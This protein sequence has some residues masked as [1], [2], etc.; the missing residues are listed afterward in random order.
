MN[1]G[2]LKKILEAASATPNPISD[3]ARL[4]IRY[5]GG[6]AGST[7]N[8][9]AASRGFD[10][11]N[12]QLVLTPELEL[13]IDEWYRTLKKGAGASASHIGAVLKAAEA[14]VEEAENP[15][16]EDRAL[17]LQAA[18]SLKIALERLARFQVQGF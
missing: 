7:V 18:T 8:I 16:A 13:C 12:G 11:T 15:N 1:V 4:T 6:M 10:W 14:V 3:T 5:R 2:E 9:K 17:L